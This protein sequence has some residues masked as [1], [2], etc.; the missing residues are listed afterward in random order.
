MVA[1]DGGQESTPGVGANEEWWGEFIRDANLIQ[2][3][4]REIS[5][6]TNGSGAQ[7]GG[8]RPQRKL[9][10]KRRAAT[11]VAQEETTR[12][13]LADDDT[14]AGVGMKSNM[15][16]ADG[17]SRPGGH[18]LYRVGMRLPLLCES[19]CRGQAET[20]E[21]VAALHIVGLSKQFAE[22]CKIEE[23]I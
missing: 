14:F 7:I 21:E 10:L 3:L 1:G 17:G 13:R 12:C 2:A 9:P 22:Y 23:P 19:G 11:D 6:I 8:R 5:E 4:A 15:S 16:D 20:F 18:L